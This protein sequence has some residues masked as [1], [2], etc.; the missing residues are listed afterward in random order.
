MDRRRAMA[1]RELIGDL[2]RQTRIAAGIV[3]EELAERLRVSQSYVSRVE[4]GEIR[5]SILQL[6]AILQALDVDLATFLA[7]V[8]ERLARR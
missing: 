3:Q 4:H 6:R 7:K 1:D 2:L 5:L 8:E